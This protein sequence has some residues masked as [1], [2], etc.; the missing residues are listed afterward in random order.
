MSGDRSMSAR[1]ARAPGALGAAIAMTLLLVAIL[2][3][4]GIA[5]EGAESAS[6]AAATLSWR[7]GW[8][9]LATWTLLLIASLRA[10]KPTVGPGPTLLLIGLGLALTAAVAGIE[11]LVIGRRRFG[12]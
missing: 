9:P 5:A 7:N 2:Q 1:P 11:R 10:L 8:L 12:G 3:P 4:L 6:G